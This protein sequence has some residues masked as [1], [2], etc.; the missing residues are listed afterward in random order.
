MQSVKNGYHYMPGRTYSVEQSTSGEDNRFS[1]TQEIIRTVENPKVHYRNHKCPPPVPILSQID[2]VHTPTP[3]FLKIHF[4]IILPSTPGSP[5]WSLSLR[6][7]HQNP[8][9]ASPLPHT[10]YMPRP[11]LDLI[12]RT[13]LGEEYRFLLYSEHKLEAEKYRI[14]SNLIHT[15]FCRFLKRKKKS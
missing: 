4:N 10:R 1:A 3:Y 13:T 7:P 2:P 6:F 14:F 11:S 8:V 5:K 12:T 9:Y 15:S